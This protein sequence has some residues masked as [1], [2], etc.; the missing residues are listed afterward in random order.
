MQGNLNLDELIEALACKLAEKLRAPLAASGAGSSVH[1]RLFTVEEATRYLGRTK[2]AVQ[3]MIASGKIPAVK[4]DRRIFLDVCDL[5]RWIELN[6][7]E[8]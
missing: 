6:K 1:P 2:E 7:Q 4:G 3:H 8:Y 5:D